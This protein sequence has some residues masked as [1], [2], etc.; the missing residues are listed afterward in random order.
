[1][2]RVVGVQDK[3]LH[4]VAG[5]VKQD[6]LGNR[7]RELQVSCW[8]RPGLLRCCLGPA[9]G[10]EHADG[11]RVTSPW[12]NIWVTCFGGHFLVLIIHSSFKASTSNVSAY[13]G[14]CK[15]TLF[16]RQRGEEVIEIKK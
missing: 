2:S 1:M 11:S 14:P 3:L 8:H 13:D 5:G 4:Q 15:N 16:K 12:P 9:A 10:Q 7:N 6:V